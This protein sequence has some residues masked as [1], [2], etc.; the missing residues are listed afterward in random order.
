MGC[1]DVKGRPYDVIEDPETRNLLVRYEELESGELREEEF[2]LV[3]LSTGLVPTERNQQLAKV[4]NIELDSLGYFKE[5]DP[6]NRPWKQGSR[7]FTC[8]A[9]PPA[10]STSPVG[11]SGHCGRHESGLGEVSENHFDG[12]RYP[13]RCFC[14]RLRLEIAGFVDA[15]NVVDYPRGRPMSSFRRRQMVVL[16]DYLA[17]C[18][19]SSKS[20]GSIEW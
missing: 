11:G 5:K 19:I 18:K 2:D 16:G 8:A 13:Y 14:L 10:P 4:L 17:P 15:P 3:V 6:F 7:V 9:E 1:G 20:T 12:R